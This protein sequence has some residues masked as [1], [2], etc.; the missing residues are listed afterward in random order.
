MRNIVLIIFLLAIFC[1]AEAL[2][3]VDPC[4][5]NVPAGFGEGS[6]PYAVSNCSS[7]ITFS[8]VTDIDVPAQLNFI[9]HNNVELDGTGQ[10]ITIKAPD[11]SDPLF[12]ILRDNI[13]IKG[14]TISYPGS[15]CMHIENDSKT[16]KDVTFKGCHRGIVV[17]FGN[18]NLFSENFFEDVDSPILLIGKS[19]GNISEPAD[20]TS[21]FDQDST[22]TLSGT[23]LPEDLGKI[24]IYKQ[25]GDELA[26]AKTIYNADDNIDAF[27]SDFETD[28]KWAYL[29][30]FDT[31]TILF[32]DTKKNTSEMSD[33]FTPWLDEDFLT[34][35]MAAC[36][37]TSW[38]KGGGFASDSDD[39]GLL[40][41]QE[42][43]DSDCKVDDDET[44]PA[45]ADS[46]MDGA[47]DSSDNCPIDDNYGQAD[48]DSDGIGDSC[49]DDHSEAAAEISTSSSSESG[50]VES[51][52]ADGDGI[53]G[54]PDNCP[55]ASNPDQEDIDF[56]GTGDACD[57]DKDNDNVVNIFDNCPSTPNAEQ[58]NT[59]D[60]HM[61]DDCDDDDDNDGVGD[62]TDICP[63]DAEDLCTADTSAGTDES[64]SGG[65]S[66]AGSDSKRQAA[67]LL[68]IF[69]TTAA[70]IVSFRATS[71][72]TRRNIW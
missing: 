68:L 4:I 72:G 18:Y 65:C 21:S 38:F 62:E 8:G 34:D 14:I 16:I 17:A 29:D 24:E 5:V 64:S 69:L 6:L 53:G 55:S 12:R 54:G 22:W 42:D 63:T 67:T 58:T 47:D 41:K 33:S 70:A 23:G 49:D 3:D 28:I 48:S 56:D 44:D 19:N 46:D 25:T 36:G 9:V 30:L 71:L 11:L 59:D 7:K 1:P 10:N 26:Y 51:E 15:I 2:S 37:D 57:D 50:G 32:I 66:L 60:D 40:N 61:G 31:Y 20:I 35:D 52:D 43:K 13:T 45:I 39:D 27:G